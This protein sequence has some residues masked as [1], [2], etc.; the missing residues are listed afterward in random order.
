M[1]LISIVVPVYNLEMY[2]DKC[3]NS[4]VMQSYK[5][6]E[7][8]LVN[9]GS[10]DSS[11]KICE[12][13]AKKDDRIIV[14]NQE[15]QGQSAARNA[16]LAIIKGEFL[17]FVDGDDYIQEDMILNLYEEIKK[18]DSDVAICNY[19]NVMQDE[20]AAVRDTLQPKAIANTTTLS[21]N[22]YTLQLL[23]GAQFAT[24][25]AKLYKK[26]SIEKI[27]FEVGLYAED[28]LYLY[29][30]LEPSFKIVII[31]YVGYNYLL[32]NDSITQG[33]K[34]NKFYYDAVRI[35]FLITEKLKE[36]FP[37]LKDNFV[38]YQMR[39]IIS[40]L[41]KVP[42]SHIF[43]KHEE[44]L[45]VIDLLNKNKKNFYNSGASLMFKGFI[46]SFSISKVISKFIAS[47]L[48]KIAIKNLS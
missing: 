33:D 20:T 28:T 25:W 42:Y 48:L 36:K 43:N 31:P 12:E 5:N 27:K 44:Y 22:E 19:K 21:G 23:S 45:F 35:S 14:I 18:T 8:I 1:D 10:T 37:L 40:F 39:T 38:I 47:F 46:F 26:S 4:L 34:K 30:I 29:E 32:R 9:D 7:I 2:L 24:V 16:A 15:N 17:S 41:I 11:K 3:I 13:W 6:I